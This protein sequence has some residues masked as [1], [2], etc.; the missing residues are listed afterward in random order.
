MY[1][2]PDRQSVV[3]SAG[4]VDHPPWQDISISRYWTE[5]LIRSIPKFL[6]TK[7]EIAK[8]LEKKKKNA[9]KRGPKSEECLTLNTMC[10]DVELG[11]ANLT[12][13]CDVFDRIEYLPKRDFCRTLLSVVMMMYVLCS[14][15]PVMYSI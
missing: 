1:R 11:N 7:R 14:P 8:E 13:D 3:S 12:L 2:A 4:V 9:E 10:A 6:A 15:S 5:E